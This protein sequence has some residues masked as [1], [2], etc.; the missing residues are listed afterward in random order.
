M[1]Y[2]LHFI[3]DGGKVFAI[4]CVDADNDY[5]AVEAA[6]RKYLGI[7]LRYELRQGARPVPSELSIP[8]RPRI[9]FGHA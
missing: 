6:R 5:G 2:E 4:D 7:K 3:G 8:S 9:I 1:R